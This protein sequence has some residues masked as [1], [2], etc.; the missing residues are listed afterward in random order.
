MH[1]PP[2]AS[3]VFSRQVHVT[4]IDGTRIWPTLV[5]CALY[6]A[7]IFAVMVQVVDMEATG[8]RIALDMLVWLGLFAVW[9][10]GL[11]FVVAGWAWVETR[12]LRPAK[13]RPKPFDASTQVD[14]GEDGFAVQG[15]G[16][17][18]WIDVLTIEGIPDSDSY[19]IVH[20]RPFGKL[21]L[22]AP[23]DELAPVVA[24]YLSLGAPARPAHAGT[25]Q[26]RAMVFCWRCF[27][28]WIWAGYALAG[29]AGIAVLGHASDAG[30][31]KTVVALCVLV[32]L[33]AWL[34]W[35][36]PLAQLSTFS[37]SRVRAFELDGTLLRST[38]GQ[39]HIDLL[40]ARVSHRRANGIGY[41]FSFLAIRPESGKKLDLALE[42][43]ADQSA[44]L[45]ALIDRGLLPPPPPPPYAEG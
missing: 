42:G 38:D 2:Q 29:A 21:M 34:V 18:D 15:L 17:I 20:T 7:L 41:A 37:P 35:A 22:T 36:I 10:V 5:A 28:T 12:W 25:L 24:H 11:V 30:F 27:R 43:G 13:G 19:L 1:P 8:W 9:M 3:P 32:P 44:L 26:S 16:H 23:V 14:V 40:R 33:V 4:R 39:W 45:H 6:S 31:V